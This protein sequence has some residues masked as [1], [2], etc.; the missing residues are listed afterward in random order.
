MLDEIVPA[1]MRQFN[2]GLKEE[3]LQLES[4]EVQR[5]GGVTRKEAELSRLKDRVG[6]DVEPIYR[7][8][9]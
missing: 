6:A 8:S 2:C 4:I 9:N 7:G 1:L 3:D 5:D